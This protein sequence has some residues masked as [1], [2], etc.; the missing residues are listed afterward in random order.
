MEES[1]MGGGD[2]SPLRYTDDEF[3]ECKRG[4]PSG[5]VLF[6]AD[7]HSAKHIELTNRQF[8]KLSNSTRVIQGHNSLQECLKTS[9]KSGLFWDL[10]TVV[11]RLISGANHTFWSSKKPKSPCYRFFC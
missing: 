6:H 7:I 5:F 9:L 1:N 4:K 10:K 8:D 2:G 3:G 11:K